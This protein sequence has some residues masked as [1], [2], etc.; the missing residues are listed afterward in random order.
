[1]EAWLQRLLGS[2]P[3][4]GVKE[5]HQQQAGDLTKQDLPQDLAVLP[6]YL[7]ELAGLVIVPYLALVRLFDLFERILLRG[8]HILGEDLVLN[9]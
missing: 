8:D 4:C 3:D 2:E 5:G 9:S 7:V 1:M 6:E